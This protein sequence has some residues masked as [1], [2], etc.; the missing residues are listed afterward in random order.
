[1]KGIR[2]ILPHGDRLEAAPGLR[3]GGLL[4]ASAVAASA[5]VTLSSVAATVIALRVLSPTEA[6]RFAFLVELLYSIGL[7]GSLGQ[8]TLQARIYQQSSAGLFNWRKDA[9]SAAAITTPFIIIVVLGLAIPY[10]LTPQEMIFLALGGE[11]F[12]LTNCISAVLAQQQHYAWSSALLRMANGLLFIPAL[13]MLANTSLRRLDFILLSLL[14]LLGATSLLGAAIL[15]RRLKPGKA[16]INIRQRLSGLIFLASLLALIVPQRGLIVVA[17][18]MLSPETV[19]AVAA[20]ASILR[21]F[22]LVGEPAGR[23]FSTEMAQH[24]D[25][26]SRGLLL[27]PW[28]AAGA[29]SAGL[30]LFVPPV[31]HRFYGGRYDAAIPLLGWLIAA[32]A[33]RFVE[34]VP[35]GFLAYRAPP[36]LLNRFTSAQ[37]ACALLG[38]IV[39]VNWTAAY[40]ARGL[41]SAGALIAAVRVA[42]SYFFFARLRRTGLSGSTAPP[43]RLIVEALET[44]SEESPI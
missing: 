15:I 32:G 20:L 18:T 1:M 3:R 14:L 7:L 23:V 37:C 10:H 25:A 11:F 31:A 27:A 29:I 17:G 19:A 33:F 35:R 30:F 22:D 8:S 24:P 5:V 43:D 34:I 26:I 36:R 41:L 2:P 21:V 6:G 40:G 13:L 38:L 39:M 9:W 44:G 42:V 12:V 4:A 16:R 28:L